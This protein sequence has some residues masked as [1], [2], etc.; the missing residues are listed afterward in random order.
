LLNWEIFYTLQE[1]Q[2]LIERC[3]REY[4]TV[5]PHSDLVIGHQNLRPSR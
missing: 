4:N 3:W 5:R 1:A 2:I